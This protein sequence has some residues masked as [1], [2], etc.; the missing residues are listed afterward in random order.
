[1]SVVQ[2]RRLSMSEAENVMAEICR[3]LE[4][5]DVAEPEM[6]FSFHGFSRVSISVRIDNSIAAN[7]VNLR[8]ASWLA[9]GKPPANPGPD[10][11]LKI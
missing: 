2:F 1:M 8:L 7:M 5:Y 9:A 4:E 11:R 10:P 3:C 6:A